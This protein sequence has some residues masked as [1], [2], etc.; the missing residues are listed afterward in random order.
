M[1]KFV[2]LFLIQTIAAFALFGQSSGD[3]GMNFQA[4]ARDASGRLIANQPV[5]V[6]I[7]LTSK[8]GV[9]QTLFSEIH[10]VRTDDQGLFNLVVGE[11]KNTVGASFADVPW[12]AQP[13]WM[14]VE[15]K[16][17]GANRFEWVNSTQLRA[18]PY[19]F[20]AETANELADPELARNLDLEKNQSIR[21]TTSG[22]EL[23]EPETHFIGTRD[24]RDLVIK[25]NGVTRATLTKEG[26]LKLF[27]GVSGPDNEETSYPMTIKGSKQGITIKVNGSRDGSNNFL[28]F[29]DDEEFLWGA[30]EGQTI[31]ELESDW[32]YILQN[33]LFALQIGSLI[34]QGIGVGLEAAGLYAAGT[35]AAASLIFAWAA[36]GF[37]ADAIAVTAAAVVLGVQVAALIAEETTWQTKI[38]EEIGVTYS[39]GAGDYAEWL[40]RNPEER[41]LIYGE[42]VGV[43][44]GVVSL[45]TQDADHVMA[46]SL[47]PIFLGNAPQP[48]QEHLYEKVAF[49]GQVPV[50]VAG[51][52]E[53]G[54]Y[55]LPSGN[56]D[57]M[58]IAVNPGQ[59]RITDFARVVGVAWESA[60]E[61]PLNIINMGVGLNNKG[62]A[63]K[64]EEISQKVDNI[65][66]FLEGKEPLLSGT[67]LPA[68][69]VSSSVAS[70]PAQKL[71]TDAEFD[72]MIDKNAGFLHKFYADTETKLHEKGMQEIPDVPGLRALFADPVTQIKAMR[73]DPAMNDHWARVDTFIK[74][75]N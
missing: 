33:T 75:R 37:Y 7:S 12:Q 23:T 25:T 17:E 53:K 30:V 2:L 74:S 11:G 68:V 66:G 6:R 63:P 32:E 20:H 52:V 57:G 22:N 26:Q 56:N 47:K 10:Q 19:A 38:R 64:V 51:K 67:G 29:G 42:I 24:D 65:I 43:K 5:Q 39:S 28:G 55:I 36:P 13:I 16:S 8:A 70:A 61:K 60:E 31:P 71:L 4:I 59:M 3:A 44:A 50:R 15:I 58:G 45:N 54:D 46:V 41:D 21:W 73:R 62:L 40:E 14:E 35:G 48:D 1:K 34:A 18:V 69:T 27:S 9:V 72:Q 49:M